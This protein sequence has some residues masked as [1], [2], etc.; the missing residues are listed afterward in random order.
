MITIRFFA[1]AREAVGK[2]EMEVD[3]GSLREILAT[4][5]NADS[6]LASVFGRCSYL[7]NGLAVH[8]FEVAIESG[9]TVDVLPPFAGG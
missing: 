6:R 5:Q 2:S 1:A 9:S 8:D 3:T 7:V 4:L